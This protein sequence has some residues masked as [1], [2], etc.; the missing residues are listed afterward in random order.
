[1]FYDWWG[2]INQ[3][4][5]AV[6]RE[7]A[8]YRAEDGSTVKVMVK[9]LNSYWD[10]G[11]KKKRIIFELKLEGKDQAEYKG[12]Y[13]CRNDGRG[14]LLVEEFKGVIS[15]NFR[16]KH[17]H[18]VIMLSLHRYCNLHGISTDAKKQK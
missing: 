1:M 12:D 15:K 13:L 11:A 9:L 10:K 8:R 17:M 3:S 16:E 18:N 5:L 7:T 4:Q 2:K 6:W 14:V